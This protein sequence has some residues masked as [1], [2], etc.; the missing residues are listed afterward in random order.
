M[1]SLMQ[2]GLTANQTKYTKN[3]G[4]FFWTNPFARR[5]FKIRNGMGCKTNRPLLVRQHERHK[6][7]PASRS[8]PM[9]SNRNIQ[10]CCYNRTGAGGYNKVRRTL[11]Y[12][13]HHLHIACICAVYC[14]RLS[15]IE[16][17]PKIS[18]CEREPARDFSCGLVSL[19]NVVFL[20][21][22]NMRKGCKS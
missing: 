1:D 20:T 2:N 8:V 4:S 22:P 18:F 15:E 7:I 10:Y 3:H 17:T 11:P 12:F 19:G 6:G 13:T 9:R 14:I 5:K 21:A 16:D